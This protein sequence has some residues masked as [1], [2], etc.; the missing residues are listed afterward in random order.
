M[1]AWLAMREMHTFRRGAF[2]LHMFLHTHSSHLYPTSSPYSK[3]C[4]G[5]WGDH[6]RHFTPVPMS[7]TMM[8]TGNFCVQN[9]GIL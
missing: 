1:Y 5:R 8:A 6:V 9:Q 4:S 7:N 3:F 2:W